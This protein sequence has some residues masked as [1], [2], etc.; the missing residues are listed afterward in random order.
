ML[1]KA[2]Q[3]NLDTA[4]ARVGKIDPELQVEI[5]EIRN[6][7]NKDE[8]VKNFSR[9]ENIERPKVEAELVS[10]IILSKLSE[11]D[12]TLNAQA[13]NKEKSPK[14][15][16][17][18]EA[19]YWHQAAEQGDAEA[20]FHLGIAYDC[21]YGIPIDHKEAEKWFCKAAEQGN[22]D[23]QTSLGANYMY[24]IGVR[25]NQDEGLK[26]FK[27][28]AEQGDADAKEEVELYE[29]RRLKKQSAVRKE[30]AN[31]YKPS[32][33][34]NFAA[35]KTKIIRA[36][37]FFIGCWFCLWCTL[38]IYLAWHSSGNHPDTDLATI[39][40][41][42]TFISVIVTLFRIPKLKS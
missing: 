21:G 14:K 20:Q 42:I 30:Y 8:L 5:D 7:K 2:Q 35:T 34:M 28:A 33:R 23:A 27:K 29:K 16:D 40:K 25:E 41:I 3:E 1:T 32:L 38:G 26:W 39:A 36:L 13:L 31:D 4:F 6:A 15:R 19:L 9:G 24:G 10:L 12:P 37:I 22:I 17:Y 11:L 18:R